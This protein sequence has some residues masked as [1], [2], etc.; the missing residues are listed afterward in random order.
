MTDKIEVIL[1]KTTVFVNLAMFFCLK[2]L[3]SSIYLFTVQHM[4][5]INYIWIQQ[6][7]LR[8]MSNNLFTSTSLFTTYS[9]GNLYDKFINKVKSQNT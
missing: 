9:Y 5:S 1:L 2:K 4:P 3:C 8:M 6:V 7:V